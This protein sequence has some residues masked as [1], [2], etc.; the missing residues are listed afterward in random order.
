M[1]VNEMLQ[2]VDSLVVEKTGKH[3]DDVQKAVIEGTWQRQSYNDIAQKSHVTEG[4]IGDIA[5][6]LWQLL[7][8]LL[9][10]DIKKSNF[11][12]TL[13][14]IYIESGKNCTIYI[15]SD[16]NN[17]SSQ[18][19]N[20]PHKITQENNTNNQ[21]KTIYHDLTLAPQIINFYNRETELK[22][23][24]EWICKG[25][26]PFVPTRLISVLGLSGIG[27]TALVRRFVDLNLEQFEVIIWKNLKF[28]KSLDLLINDLLNVCQ[29]EAK[30]ILD[31]KLKQLFNIFTKKKCL[32][33]LDDVQNIFISG[34]IAGQYQPEYKDYQKFFQ[35]ITEINHQSIII[36]ISQEK[37]AEMNSL[38]Q[39]L[40]LSNCLE[41]SGLNDI[42]IL[43][44]TGLNNQ[45][46]WLKLIQLYEG[47][48][49]YLKD[50]VS[51]IQDVYDGEITEFLAESSLIFTQNMQ[52]YF[53]D[54]FKR[55]SPMEQQ[56]ILELS[57]FEQPI[58]REKLNQNLAL[59]S[60]DFV[61]GLQSLQQRYLVTKI[62]QDKIMFKLSPLFR[63]YVKNCY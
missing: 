10:E 29:E 22:T 43:E 24:S 7:S 30:E 37:C 48:F 9:N 1:N 42:N 14:R 28:P 39:Q 32:I 58:S 17:Y 23:L 63:E 33:I 45:D 5:S 6:E 60:V 55:L 31:D 15:N 18:T 49:N 56:I 25:E 13:E 57:K 3:L 44:N 26:R 41:L 52:S 2:F 20:H 62:K 34:Q 12:S 36:L 21:E 8:E 61:N 16:N 27:K 53:N 54:L 46:S 40:D 51:L 35:M 38:N 50:I 11:R 59:S 47:N 4:Y 19:F